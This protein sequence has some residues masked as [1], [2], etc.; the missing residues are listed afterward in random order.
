M[1]LVDFH[2]E[3]KKMMMKLGLGYK[4]IHDFPVRSDLSAF[5]DI[6]IHYVLHMLE[7]AILESPVPAFFDIMRSP[8]SKRRGISRDLNLE[9]AWQAN[10]KMPLSI[11]FDNVEHTMQPLVNNMKYFTRLVGNQVRFT[12]P[13]CYPSWTDVPEE[14][15]AWLCSIIKSYFDIQGNR[16]PDE[17]LK[18][19]GPSRPYDELSAKDWQ[20]CIDFLTSPTFVERSTKN[21]ANQGKAKYS[22][23]QWSKI[24]FATR[25]DEDKLVELRETQQTHVASNGASVDKY[26]IAKEVLGERRGHFSGDLHNDNPRFALYEAQLRRMERTI[27]RLT[28]N[29]KHSIPEVVPEQDETMVGVWEIC[30][31]YV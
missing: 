15:R 28:A 30:R 16:S 18:Q 12:V 7:E 14:L 19:H 4:S 10:G 27:Q 31:F 3:A 21:K 13:P 22:S 23:M 25:Y 5:F 9:K 20:K 17:Y 6:M 2:Y 1:N 8:P 26:A 29:L 11:A 24:F